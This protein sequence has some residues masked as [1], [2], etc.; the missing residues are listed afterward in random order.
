M[1]AAVLPRC[2]SASPQSV[3]VFKILERYGPEPGNDVAALT[4]EEV[5]PRRADEPRARGPAS[6]LEDLLL[7]EVRHGVFLIRIAHEAGVRL[8][9]VGDPLPRVADH[10]PA[11]DRT[12]T[13]GQGAH[14]N[15]PTRSV[16]EIGTLGCWRSIAPGEP[17]FDSRC[18]IE[19][20]RHLPFRLRWQASPG[21]TTERLRLVPIHMHDGVPGLQRQGEIEALLEPASADALPEQRILDALTPPPIPAAP[22]PALAPSITTVLDEGLELRVR[23]WGGGNAER[24]DLHG[25]CPLLIIEDERLVGIGA[26]PERSAGYGDVVFAEIRVHWPRWGGVDQ[27]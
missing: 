20:G 9:C 27:V 21:P 23:H 11:A 5:S 14:V 6:A 26:Q 4:L 1:S 18:G 22:S 2:S 19:G 24:G 13:S 10:L 16:V 15:R 17:L 8:E 7:A 12:V 3:M 25:M